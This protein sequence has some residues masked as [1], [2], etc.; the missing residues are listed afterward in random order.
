MRDEQIRAFFNKTC[1]PDEA[2]AVAKYLRENPSQLQRWLPETEWAS[3]LGEFLPGDATAAI[4][5]KIDPGPRRRARKRLLV[6]MGV[7]ASLLGALFFVYRLNNTPNKPLSAVSQIVPAAT[8]PTKIINR[9]N[10]KL[11]ILLPDQSRVVL[12]PGAQLSYEGSFLTGTRNLTLTGEAY[13]QVAPDK[14]RP[15]TV[16][17][18]A[19]STT[20]LGTEFRVRQGVGSG[21]SIHLIKGRV[22]IKSVTGELKGWSRDIFLLPGEKMSY[23]GLLAKLTV[24]RTGIA[25]AQALHGVAQKARVEEMEN[26]LNFTGER[27]SAALDRISTFYRIPVVYDPQS[28]K[29]MHFTGQISRKDAL[30]VILKAIAQMNHL[31]VDST[32]N[33]FFLRK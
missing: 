7:A 20:A 22:V 32:A 29:G 21:M 6:Q 13:F 1:K 25:D 2:A 3:A 18:G 26:G 23:D 28:L 31:Q 10:K 8:K 16:F 12:E 33:Q 15:F 4:W 5:K 30:S 17:S 11:D 14:T 9:E 27:L 19:F 24:T